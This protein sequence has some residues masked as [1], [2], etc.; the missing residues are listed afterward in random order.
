MMRLT[1]SPLNTTHISIAVIYIA[2]LVLLC[3]IDS[4]HSANLDNS[5]ND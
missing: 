2:V 4:I 3:V 5:D 1:Q